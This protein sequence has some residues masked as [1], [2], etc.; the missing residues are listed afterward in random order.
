VK[1]RSQAALLLGAL[2]LSACCQAGQGDAQP[3]TGPAGPYAQM[4][5][6]QREEALRSGCNGMQSCSMGEQIIAGA[7][8]AP[9]HTRLQQIRREQLAAVARAVE[10]SKSEPS[11]ADPPSPSPVVTA[12]TAAPSPGGG[13]TGPRCRDGSPANCTGRGCCSHHGGVAR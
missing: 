7:A 8:T 2:L 11:R 1:N 5:M 13:Y 9:E 10:A 3:F 6:A 4:T 12:T